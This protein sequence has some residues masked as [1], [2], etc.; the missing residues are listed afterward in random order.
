MM[1]TV[2][3][4]L[5]PSGFATPP[6]TIEE[7][8]TIFNEVIADFKDCLNKYKA[9]T[10]TFL[11]G[12]FISMDQEIAVGDMTVVENIQTSSSISAV[13][14]CPL[15]GEITIIHAFQT[16]GKTIPI[17]NTKF[18]VFDGF[19]L[20]QTI[21][22]F[23]CYYDTPY[24]Y[25]GFVK[26]KKI[27]D[28]KV[29]ENGKATL[30]LEPNKTYEIV[31]YPDITD[32]DLTNLFQSYDELIAQCVDWLKKSW[33]NGQKDEWIEYLN[34]GAQ[35]DYVEGLKAFADGIMGTLK[36]IWDLI[37]NIFKFMCDPIKYSKQL[38]KYIPNP[39]ELI[40]KYDSAKDEIAEMLMMLKDE[41]M[42]AII[43][44]AVFSYFKLFTGQQ[45]LNL[46]A[47]IFGA[48]ITEVI[49]SIILPGA[50]AKKGFDALM[51]F[52]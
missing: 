19:D 18:A 25:T 49:I 36:D 39:D 30:Q 3:I 46:S 35:I 2:E 31:F 16:V 42:L 41:A 44:Y 15:T 13:T 11:V 50:I 48:V 47:T 7:A 26:H 51:N 21:D 9:K 38:A 14:R 28:G 40:E 37:C 12:R 5:E 8:E 34:K 6:H 33:E 17:P 43:F 20:S 22:D 24:F 4:A 45:I 27:L 32:V 29:D 1:D 52:T 10:D 23:D